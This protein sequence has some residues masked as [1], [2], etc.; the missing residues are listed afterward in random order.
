[1]HNRARV[2]RLVRRQHLLERIE[3]LSYGGFLVE[4]IRQLS[5]RDSPQT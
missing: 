2:L 5:A 1:V 3:G 4:I